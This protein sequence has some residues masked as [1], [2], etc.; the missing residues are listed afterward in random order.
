MESND[1][2]VKVVVRVRPW[3]EREKL[4]SI[5]PVVSTRSEFKEV[6]V[7]KEGYGRAISKKHVFTFDEVFTNFTS[8]EEVNS[9]QYISIGHACQYNII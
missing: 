6:S 8:Q 5:V 7:V 4:A 3:S 2:S 1:S 9:S